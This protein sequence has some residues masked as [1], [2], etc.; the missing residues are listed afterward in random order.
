M[1]EPHQGRVEENKDDAVNPQI[2]NTEMDVENTQEQESQVESD[3][4]VKADKDEGSKEIGADV[5]ETK[6]NADDNS[7]KV[8]NEDSQ[9]QKVREKPSP[10]TL[11]TDLLN[12]HE[13]DSL[14]PPDSP[15][16]SLI[17]SLRTQLSLLSDQSIQLNQK[18]ISSIGKSADLEDELHELQAQHRSLTDHAGELEKEKNKWEESMNTGLLVERSQI[19]DEMQKLAQG[20]VEEERRR[21]TAEEKRREVENE[22]DDLT[23]KLFDQANAMVATERMSRAE[24]EARLKSTEENLA[25]AE[26]AVRDMQLHLQSLPPSAVQPSAISLSPHTTANE[27]ISSISISRKYLSSHVPYSEFLNFI[28]HLRTLRPIKETSKNTFPPPL[29]TNLL[30]QPFLARTIIEDNDPTLRLDTAPDLSWLSRRSVS[31]AIISGDLIV[32]PVSTATL[33]ASTSSSVQ[34]INCS[35]CG[36]S[37]F[38]HQQQPQSPAGTSHFGPPPVHPQRTSNS[39]TSRFSLKP[40]F[41][42]TTSSTSATN[43]NSTPNVP[44][45]S[46]SPVSSPAIGPG[47]AITSVYVFRIAKPQ[48]QSGGSS[49]D[50]GDSKLYPLCRTGWCLERMRATCALWHFVR[51]GVVHVIWHG[52]DGTGTTSTMTTITENHQQVGVESAKP[53]EQ[54]DAASEQ[55]SISNG[56]GEEQTQQ[57]PPPL[58]QR[59]KSSWALGFKL[60]DKSTGGWTRGWKS[61]GGTANSPPDS[62]GAGNGEE[63]RRDSVG[64]LGA[65]RDENGRVQTAGGLGL[66]EALNIDE[67]ETER[68]KEVP[69]IQEPLSFSTENEKDQSTGIESRQDEVSAKLD[70]DQE[71]E[72]DE[73]GERGS[74]IQAP[75]LS[76]ATSNIS[77][78]NTSETGFHTPKGGQADLPSE[79]GHDSPSPSEEVKRDEQSTPHPPSRVDTETKV[80]KVIELASP[81]SDTESPTKTS[82]AGV[83][84][85]IPRRAAGRN[86]LSQLSGGTSTPVTSEPPTPVKDKENNKRQDEDEDEDELSI[87]K[88]L[89]DEL[90]QRKSEDVSRDEKNEVIYNG[91]GDEQ[92]NNNT[93]IRDL[94]DVKDKDGDQKEEEEEEEEEPPFTPVNLDEKFPLSPLQQQTFPSSSSSS[95]SRP[96]SQIAATAPPPPLPPRHPKT[97]VLQL[98]NSTGTE[99]EKRYFSIGDKGDHSWEGKTWEKIVKLKEEMWKS[100]IGVLDE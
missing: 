37:I 35:L 90:E 57:R 50:K 41:A 87:L 98:S 46:Q 86:R 60:S 24:A 93:E 7:E 44:S 15:T 17:T 23:A 19:K 69:V 48:L 49:G 40:F 38:I 58:P 21:G 1:S 68:E 47:G 13:A 55:P 84:P 5:V 99:G 6:I 36:K 74:S 42:T 92:Q 94:Q 95:T 31:Q 89:R 77:S 4:V 81:A 71:G 25:A 64:S 51:T 29:I 82:A 72:V 59:K 14:H 67:K 8:N 10:L 70:K 100:R 2:Q 43:T 73:E 62:P 9:P 30:T 11:P 3:S 97:P 66:G 12:P 18:L 75:P 63:T 83:P 96:N 79:D 52:D 78:I 16:T 80:E 33:L 88:E 91:N 53:A 65:E 61:S 28:Q 39:T 45:P 56:S 54:G 76:R 26:A 85:P 32:E 27:G 34:D 20:L 22:V